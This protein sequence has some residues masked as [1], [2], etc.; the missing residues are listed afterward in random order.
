MECAEV[1]SLNG[2]ENRSIV[3]E[4]VIVRCYHAPPNLDKAV[5]SE[6]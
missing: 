3:D 5:A 2:L 6:A 1:G 4:T